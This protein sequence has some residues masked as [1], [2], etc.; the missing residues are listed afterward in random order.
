MIV[1][2]LRRGYTGELRLCRDDVTN[3]RY[4]EAVTIYFTQWEENDFGFRTNRPPVIII[5]WRDQ[6]RVEPILKACKKQGLEPVPTTL[7]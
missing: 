7:A 3:D 6:D 1:A 5:S 2:Y 4:L